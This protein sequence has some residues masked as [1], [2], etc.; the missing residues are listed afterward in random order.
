M[1]IRSLSFTGTTWVNLLFGSHER[2]LAIGPPQRAWEAVEKDADRVCVVHHERCTLWPKFVRTWDRDRSFFQQLAEH[3]GKSHIVLNNPTRELAEKELAHPALEVKNILVV[4]DARAVLA[5]F[6]RHR[7]ERYANVYDAVAQWLK[8]ALRRMARLSRRLT[9]PLIVR[10]E[11]V[12][13][14]PHQ[15]LDTVGNH[16]GIDYPA[17]ATNYW[18]FEHHLALGNS[19]MVD[20]LRRLQGAPGLPGFQTSVRKA[21]YDELLEQTRSQ[22]DKR[23]VD[24]SWREILTLQDRFAYDYL[25]GELHETFGYE[26]DRFN[27]DELRR[28]LRDWSL[29][30]ETDAP[31]EDAPSVPKHPLPMTS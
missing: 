17:N 7:P 29:P 5:S 26:R 28:C 10:Y 2:A 14:D 20:L 24:E 22:P 4:R 31:P 15:L 19:G 23:V 9:D 21:Y 13:E 25:C 12:M 3:S 18:D 27:L 30:L 6:L 16:I 1:V 8:P 11:D